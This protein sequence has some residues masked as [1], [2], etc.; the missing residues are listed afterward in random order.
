MLFS[1][2]YCKISSFYV[3]G[4]FFLI[5]KNIRIFVVLP[6]WYE[7]ALHVYVIRKCILGK[8]SVLFVAVNHHF[9]CVCERNEIVNIEIFLTWWR[10]NA[11]IAEYTWV[12]VLFSIEKMSNKSLTN[13]YFYVFIQN[14]GCNYWQRATDTFWWYWNVLDFGSPC[15]W[16]KMWVYKINVPCGFLF[17]FLLSLFLFLFFSLHHKN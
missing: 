16:F 6:F 17:L 9:D 13:P 1:V 2:H 3:F 15:I 8:S 5:L 4:F 7:I 11:H 12:F 10:K 14:P